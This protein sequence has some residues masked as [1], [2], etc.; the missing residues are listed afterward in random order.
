[1]SPE[2]KEKVKLE[3]MEC[4]K[5]ELVVWGIRAK[6]F[7]QTRL[8]ASAGIA[9]TRTLAKICSGGFKFFTYH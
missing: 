9:A 4:T 5:E 1:L 6:I 8:T 3:S 7:S 2:A